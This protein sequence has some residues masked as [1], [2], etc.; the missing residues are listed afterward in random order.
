V[1]LLRLEDDDKIA[2]AASIMEE[3]DVPEEKK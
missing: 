2:A 1:R 3:Q